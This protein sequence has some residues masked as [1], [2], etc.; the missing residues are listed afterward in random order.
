MTRFRLALLAPGLALLAGCSF[1]AFT[2]TSERYGTVQAVHMTL[3]C[4]DTY[5][6]FDR[7]DAATMLVSTN[8][9]NEVLVGCLDNG[10]PLADRQRE[11]A[12]LYLQ[13]KTDRPNCRIVGDTVLSPVLREFSYVCPA[14]P[15]AVS[16]RL[17]GRS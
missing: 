11:A 8:G 5:E 1:E 16:P 10:P 2:Y 15:A 9:L 17:R 13:E 3:R 4:R 7:R 12:R 6:V 14:D